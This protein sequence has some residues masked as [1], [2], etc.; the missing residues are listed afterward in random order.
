VERKHPHCIVD[1]ICSHAAMRCSGST[2]SELRVQSMV[3][4]N[5]R[6]DALQE[7]APGNSD[8]AERLG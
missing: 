5:H 6:L 3:V 2:E 4:N 7:V 1:S 8:D